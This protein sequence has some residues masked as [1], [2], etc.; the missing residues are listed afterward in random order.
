MG[1]GAERIWNLAGQHFPG[2]A[3]I[4]DL[5]HARRHLWELVHELHPNNEAKQKAWMRVHQKRL[6][7]KGKIEKLVAAIAA[8]H[9]SN[10]EVAEKIRLEADYFRRNAER[11]RHP[12]FRAQPPVR[13]LRRHRS[14]L[15]GGHRLTPQKIRYVLDCARSQRHPR[16]PLLPPQRPL[17]GLLGSPEGC[18]TLTS[19]SRTQGALSWRPGTG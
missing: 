14:R 13:G 8:I 18:L 4:V 11:M 3:Q 7:D 9:S 12:G 16:P 10:P 15:Q 5:Y 6:L 2:A 17:R 19:A 1:D